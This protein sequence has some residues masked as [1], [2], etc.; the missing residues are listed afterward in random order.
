MLE[1]EGCTDGIWFALAN[2]SGPP[3]LVATVNGNG[4]P[5]GKNSKG[6]PVAPLSVRL[7]RDSNFEKFERY[8][9]IKAEAR[10]CADDPFKP[11]PVD[12]GVDRVTATF[13][14]RIDSVSKELHAAHL[15]KSPNAKLDF[16]GF[17]Q[18]GMFDT[19]LVVESVEKIQAVDAFG[20]DKP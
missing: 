12:C 16:K 2:G 18:M 7:V 9:R 5:G 1:D 13:T 8:M 4:R 17:G 20:R 6:T 10:P 14:G 3:G 11:T 15:K 19:Q